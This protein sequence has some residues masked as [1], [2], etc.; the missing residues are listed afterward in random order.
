MRSLRWAHFCF[1]EKMKILFSPLKLI[2]LLKNCDSISREIKAQNE[3]TKWYF[4]KEGRDRYELVECPSQKTEYFYDYMLTYQNP[5]TR[6][7]EKTPG[8]EVVAAKIA[9]IMANSMDCSSLEFA[10]YPNI[11]D[12]K[13]NPLVDYF[14]HKD[15]RYINLN[16]CGVEL[17]E[18]LH[19]KISGNYCL[20]WQNPY[21]S[22]SFCDAD[23]SVSDIYKIERDIIAAFCIDPSVKFAKPYSFDNNISV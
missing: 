8:R 13:K 3:G 17:L 11:L 9:Y 10:G 14:I 22:I 23:G 7:W 4:S 5:D 21:K 16:I 2:E 20:D 6:R 15:F 12:P 18:A 1:F 19:R